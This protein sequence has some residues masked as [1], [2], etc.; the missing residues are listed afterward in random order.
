MISCYQAIF[1][2]IDFISYDHFLSNVIQ[3]GQPS[4]NIQQALCIG[5][6][7]NKLKNSLFIA[8]EKER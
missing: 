6:I 5:D 4:P 1:G 3:V 8:E 2:E 7:I